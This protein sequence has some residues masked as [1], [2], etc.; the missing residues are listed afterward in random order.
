M[1]KR[2]LIV[3]DNSDLLELLRLSFKA[4]GF[5]IATATNG[6]DAIK[7]TRSLNPD[8]ILLDLI[9]PELD[10]FAVCEILRKD[11]ET[12]SVPIVVLTGLSSQFTR[13]AGLESGATEFVTKPMSPDHLVVKV[14]R[15]LSERA[16]AAKRE[17]AAAAELSHATAKH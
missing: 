8:L 13:Y 11:P 16:A 12:V 3:E 2:I 17:K 15:L 6:I 4:A 10:G 1:R 9:L 5:S 14:K 7:K